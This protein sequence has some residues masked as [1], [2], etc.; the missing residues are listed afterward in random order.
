MIR[1][2]V[3]DID[4]TLV[5][6]DEV[7]SDDILLMKRQLE[8][9][10]ILFSVATGRTESMAEKFIGKPKLKVPYVAC[11]GATVLQGSRVYRHLQ[12]AAAPL[13]TFIEKADSL[14]LSVINT[15]DGIEY[16]WRD[17]P[18]ILSQRARFGRYQTTRQFTEQEWQTLRLD[19]ISIMS[20]RDDD[21]IAFLETMCRNLHDSEIGY[22]R[23]LDRSVEVVNHEATKASGVAFLAHL[24]GFT[25]AEVMFVG[26][27]QNDMELIQAAGVGVAVGNS[28]EE[29]KASAD[30]VCSQPC[31]LGVREA[32][33]RF[34]LQGARG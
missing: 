32:V 27:H 30:Y 33:D 18:Y 12:F 17:A 13:R 3:C 34:L 1:F 6:P 28:T 8:E 23:Y 15:I 11:N 10:G 16:A 4:G 19:K 22:T 20:D 25:M 29:V 7:L 2:V 5:G 14:G 9:R 21:D 31:A 24:L 26:D